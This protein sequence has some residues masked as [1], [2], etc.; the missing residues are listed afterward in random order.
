MA[1]LILMRHGQSVWN[2]RNLFTG[3]VDVPLSPK[4]I[5]E[6]LEGGKQI[7]HIPIDVIFTSTLGRAQVTAMLAMSTHESGKVP[8]FLHPQGRLGEW[9]KHEAPEDSIIPVHASSEI[10]ER[11]YGDL[12][13]LNKAETAEKFGAEQVK[14]WRRSYDIPPPNGESLEMTA[15]RSIP[16]F[17]EKIVPVLQE[18]KNVFVSAHGNSLR[19]IVMVLDKLSREEVLSLE[20]PT[21]K[22][23][24]YDYDKGLFEKEEI[25]TNDA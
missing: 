12:Q 21:G 19:S 1:K 20:I 11:M 14:I 7:A 16:Y 6:A 10:N 5:E 2:L 15:N 13:G 17:Q 4:G 22:P 24:L 18:G 3:W 8:V 25:V 23:I 9:S